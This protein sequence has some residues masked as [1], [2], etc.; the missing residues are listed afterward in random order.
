MWQSADRPERPAPTIEEAT[1]L[2]LENAWSRYTDEKRQF[3]NLKKEEFVAGFN[4]GVNHERAESLSIIQRLGT[5]YEKFTK[6]I[7]RNKTIAK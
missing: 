7:V 3:Y 6:I 4:A 5:D 2:A 1:D